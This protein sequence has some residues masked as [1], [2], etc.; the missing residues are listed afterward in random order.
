MEGGTDQIR[1]LVLNR[2]RMVAVLSLK[3]L[4]LSILVL[5]AAGLSAPVSAGPMQVAMDDDQVKTTVVGKTL[6][7]VYDD[8]MPWRETYL[9]DGEVD[10]QDSDFASR[11]D[12][13]VKDRQLCTFY[14]EAG[15]NGGC[16]YVVQ[17]SAN[18]FDFY[19]IDPVTG[20]PSADL[21]AMRTG[22]GWTARGWRSDK[23][24]TCAD[25]LIS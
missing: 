25:G 15:M 19:G 6:L 5:L 21:Q 3:R 18:C 24:K 20:E 12:W 7:G 13:S 14:V 22:Y 2:L 1:V 23:P 4:R 16:F 9:I 10:Y 17:R 11:G 8:G